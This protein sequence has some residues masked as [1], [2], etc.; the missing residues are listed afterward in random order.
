[1]DKNQQNTEWIEKYAKLLDSQFRIPFT[2][3][4]FGI[5]PIVGLIPGLGS[6]SGLILGSVLIVIS[7]KSGVSSQTK[8][9]MIRNLL[10]DFLF[11]LIPIIGNIKDFFYKANERNFK[12]LDEHIQEGKHDG[13][14]AEVV[15]DS[16]KK[17][18]IVVLIVSILLIALGIYICTLIF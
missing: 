2:N 17:I 18:F 14:V 1:M 8:A 16:A 11:G 3:I 4:T 5:D 9:K 12:L 7:A 10:F 15:V 6:F 13:S